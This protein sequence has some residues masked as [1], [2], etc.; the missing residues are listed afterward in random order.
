M[1][2][3]RKFLEKEIESKQKSFESYKHYINP[4]SDED[5]SVLEAQISDKEEELKTYYWFSSRKGTLSTEISRLKKRIKDLKLLEER[6]RELGNLEQQLYDTPGQGWGGYP[7]TLDD[8]IVEEYRG[9]FLTLSVPLTP[10]VPF[11]NIIMI[12]ETGSGKSSFLRA[13]TSALKSN[14]D[15]HDNYRVGPRQGKE[16]TVTKRIHLEPMY[17]GDEGQQLPC[18]FYDVPGIEQNKKKLNDE[19]LQKFL[20]QN[21]DELQE[22]IDG[23]MI[24]D[25]DVHSDSDNQPESQVEAHCILYVIHSNT[26]LK[27]K[28]PS[29]QA[30]IKI[31]R[32]RNEED[33]IRQFVVITAI[34]QL[35]VPNE[36]MKNAYSYQCVRKYCEKVSQE[37]GLD[38]LH[39]IPVSNY[40]EE[41]ASNDAKKAMSLFNLWRVFKSGKEYIERRWNRKETRYF[42]KGRK[43]TSE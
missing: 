9:R 43:W 16:P 6:E 18:K 17:I 19:E 31:Q 12:G 13:F 5:I 3:S 10:E 36:D 34:D 1:A 29:L 32:S 7:G 35:G 15:I 33:G 30:M 2:K 14:T 4:D 26:D 28:P 25:V 20:Q 11:I 27:N 40:F 39:V 42:K 37:F 38:L 23:K 8:K 21:I 24:L 41:V 22:I